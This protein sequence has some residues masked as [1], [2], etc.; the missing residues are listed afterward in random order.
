MH[1]NTWLFNIRKAEGGQ[2]INRFCFYGADS[3]EA[4]TNCIEWTENQYDFTCIADLEEGEIEKNEGR[5]AQVKL[6]N[7]MLKDTKEQFA[8]VLRIRKIK[9]IQAIKEI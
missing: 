2:I 6:E 5:R 7:E 3:E 9:T 4:H 8:N 1:K